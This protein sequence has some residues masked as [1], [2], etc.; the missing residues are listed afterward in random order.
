M[1]RLT[2]TSASLLTTN[3][4]KTGP[5]LQNPARISTTH[6]RPIPQSQSFPTPLP[7]PHRPGLGLS[8]SGRGRNYGSHRSSSF[9]AVLDL[10]CQA[11]VSE[12][13]VGV[14][15]EVNPMRRGSALEESPM[16]AHRVVD[17]N[18]TS[19]RA[20]TRVQFRPDTPV[21]TRPALTLTHAVTRV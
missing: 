10:R 19:S 1:H 17:S 9:G 14:K 12:I 11:T 4:N 7:P 6:P 13:T 5:A 20:V 21:L 8:R 15:T 2:S 3:R 16:R 18:P